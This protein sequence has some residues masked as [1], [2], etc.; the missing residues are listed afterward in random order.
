MSWQPYA[1]AAL[2][3]SNPEY[4]KGYFDVGYVYPFSVDM[5]PNQTVSDL[6]VAIHVDSDFL[7]R[8]IR[9]DRYGGPF[10]VRFCDANGYWLSSDWMIYSLFLHGT[11]PGFYIVEPEFVLPAGSRLGIEIRNLTSSANS[12]DMSFHGVKRFR[13]PQ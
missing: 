9:L 13:R 7:L 10:Q 4:P 5:A 2:I 12:V 1:S 6:A 3:G 11:E 8:A